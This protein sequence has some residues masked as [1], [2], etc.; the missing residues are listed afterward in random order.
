[1]ATRA[2]VIMNDSKGMRGVYSHWDGY[3]SGL[4]V[5]LKNFFNTRDKVEQLI[6]GGDI[7]EIDDFGGV[8]YFEAGNPLFTGTTWQEV[9]KQIPHNGHIYVSIDGVW[10][11]AESTK[12]WLQELD[13][14]LEPESVTTID[15]VH[16]WIS[17]KTGGGRND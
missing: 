13:A 7:A 14:A 6:D 16:D 11:Y 5:K 2:A 8:R 3:L 10:H 17:G 12:Y 9:A 4:G 1:M 15:D